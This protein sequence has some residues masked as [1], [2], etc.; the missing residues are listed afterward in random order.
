VTD[1]ADSHQEVIVLTGVEGG[2]VTLYGERTERGWRF[3]C[4]FVDQ[5]PFILADGE[6]QREIRRMTKTVESWRDALALLD[7][8]G[9]L[10]LPAIHVHPEFRQQ[11]LQVFEKRLGDDPR[12]ERELERWRERCAP[13]RR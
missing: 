2:G 3:S 11:V 1:G 8:K 4:N 12:N 5:T 13:S 10:R 6:D 7:E 9:W